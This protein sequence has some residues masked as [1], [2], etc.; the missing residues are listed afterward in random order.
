MSK[1]LRKKSSSGPKP[2]P[3]PEFNFASMLGGDL[4]EEQKVTAVNNICK[5]I[6]TKFL[7]LEQ[8]Y[9]IRIKLRPLDTKFCLRKDP[10]VNIPT[11]LSVP[12][13]AYGI[14]S[15]PI[16]S[17]VTVNRPLHVSVPVPLGVGVRA[18]PFGPSLGL[19]AVGVIGFSPSL[20]LGVG[21]ANDGGYE[22]KLREMAERVKIYQEIKKYLESITPRTTATTPTTATT[23]TTSTPPRNPAIEKYFERNEER[24]D[25]D[26]GSFLDSDD[27]DPYNTPE[28][29][30]NAI[31]SLSTTTST[32]G[33]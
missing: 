10:V 22:A 2:K 29:I 31:N 27:L 28:K 4:T 6:N 32:H 30:G 23:L 16:V 19:G 1:A 3:R 13:S 33:P 17:P 7:V 5:K 11:F 8:R 21:S 18:S 26:T 15:V 14:A 25:V 12:N 9:S 20:M 24:N